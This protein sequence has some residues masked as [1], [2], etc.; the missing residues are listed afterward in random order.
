M[1]RIKHCTYKEAKTKKNYLIKYLSKVNLI[2]KFIGSGFWEMSAHPSCQSN[3][4]TNLDF[5]GNEKIE[6][7]GVAA[8]NSETSK[9]GKDRQNY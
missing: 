4:L 7:E 2:S 8:S 1:S 5:K 6:W 9:W 3:F